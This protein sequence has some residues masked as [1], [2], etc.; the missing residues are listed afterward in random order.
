M[1]ARM[2]GTSHELRQFLPEQGLKMKSVFM[3]R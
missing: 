2:A 1:K 3:R